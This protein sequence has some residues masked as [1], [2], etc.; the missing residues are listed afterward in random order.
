MAGATVKNPF[1]AFRFLVEITGLVVGGFNEVSGLQVETETE[2]YREGGV[3][4]YI[5]KLPKVTKSPLLVLK[6]GLTDA[7][8][9]WGWHQE[10]AA[11]IIKRKSVC[12]IMLDGAGGERWRWT[13]LDAYPVK[14]SGPEFR[15]DGSALAVETLE[16]AHR[17]ISKG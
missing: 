12:V 1:A 16:L 5:H 6:R 2:E 17:G 9:L 7:D 10:V 4:G 3:N 15:G 13:F 11:G 14:W 8:N